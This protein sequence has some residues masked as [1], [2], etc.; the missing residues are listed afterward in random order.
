MKL[1]ENPT[2][3]IILSENQTK[4][5]FL[6]ENPTV[7]MELLVCRKI[8]PFIGGKSDTFVGKVDE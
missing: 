1:S 2:K 7:I 6:S 3:Y 8:L 4:Y 5:L